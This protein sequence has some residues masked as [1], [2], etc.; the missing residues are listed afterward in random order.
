VPLLYPPHP[1]CLFEDGHT[2][3]LFENPK[4]IITADALED[5][6]PK[7]AHIEECVH[8]GAYAAGCIRYEAAA[9]FHARLLSAPNNAKPLLL[10]ALFDQPRVL[11]GAELDAFWRQKALS[12]P[13]CTAVKTAAAWDL[14]T[15]S[16][17]AETILNHI[18]VGDIYQA[19]LT[20]PLQLDVQG[21]AEAFYARLRQNQPAAYGAFLNLDDTLVLSFSPERFFAVDGEI[22][23][24]QPMKGTAP[25]NI[26]GAAE[27]LQN[28][29]KNKAENLMITDLLRNDLSQV[30]QA[31]SVSVPDLFKI[32]RLPSVYQ[33]TSQISAKRSADADLHT[34]MQA[35]FP[36]GSVTGAPKLSAMQILQ[37][38]EA[39]P[40]G[41]YC[42]AIGMLSPKGNMTF[43]VPIR[44]IVQEKAN[45]RLDIGSGIVADSTAT[46]EYEECLLKAKFL[47]AQRAPFSLLE[48]MGFSKA[49][50]QPSET[51]P[52]HWSRHQ[53]RLTKAAA[54]FGFTPVCEDLSTQVEAF[55]S[56]LAPGDYKIRLLYSRYGALSLTAS[57]APAKVNQWRVRL[58]T[59]DDHVDTDFLRFKT[60]FRDGYARA[61]H[62]AKR[63]GPCDEVFLIDADEKLLEGCYSNIFLEKNGE[64]L[65]PRQ[66]GRFL[67]GIL[68]EALIETN[69]V[70]EADLSVSDLATADRV[71]AGNAL[72]GLI[73]VTIL[74]S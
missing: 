51:A 25:A 10:F 73:S 49:A 40:R 28:D 27:A 29:A 67:P 60:T 46:A 69:Q 14:E 13:V 54:H 57:S 50:Q 62:T 41:I 22:I 61:L 12:S 18:A 8:Q 45:T 19:N 65:T 35:L 56:G 63:R 71:F 31:G 16:K 24:T 30:A 47:S 33:M 72:R 3:Q 59:L 11:K 53:R 5:V 48:T 74:D 23:R 68:R 1:Y 55:C 70:R 32:E 17:A 36:C 52:R 37:R 2:G 4:A 26:P 66:N 20:F 15:Y 34:L 21:S 7:L 43:S 38:L 39:G 64:L 42:G 6:G 9:A 44:T 58:A